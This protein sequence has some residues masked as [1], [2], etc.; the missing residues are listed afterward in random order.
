MKFWGLI[1]LVFILALAGFFLFL[2]EA[3]VIQISTQE[4]ESSTTGAVLANVPLDT[5]VTPEAAEEKPDL[6][7]AGKNSFGDLGYQTQ[8]SNPPAVIKGIYVTGWTA[9]SEKRINALV[10]LI[11]K[12]EVNAIVIDIK[13]YS[14]FISYDINDS[15]FESAGALKELRILKPNLLIKKLHDHG[16]YA[17][18]RV[19]VFQ[20]SILAKAHPEW[21][22]KNK[23]T[24]ELWRDR[25]SLAWMDP[26]SKEVWDYNVALAKDALG[27]GFDEVN[28][29]YIRF[30]SD[31]NLQEIEYPYWDGLREKH[32]AMRDFFKYL[33]ENLGEAK[34][35]ADLFGLVTVAIDDLG[36][37]QKLED[38]LLY[39]DFVAPMVYPS[40]YANG[41]FGFAS[42]ATHPYEIVHNSILGAI[43]KI[44]NFEFGIPG[45]SSSTVNNSGTLP[46]IKIREARAKLRPWLQDFDLGADYDAEKIRA[47]MRGSDEAGGSGWML[48]D[49]KNIYT[50]EALNLET[51]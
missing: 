14:G 29:D 32:L 12:T 41:V 9:G 48:W 11:D 22:L 7:P 24:G 46:A 47:Q 3:R 31:G 34:I 37:G 5:L 25:K 1:T 36:I 20:D 50:R 6:P 33:R 8:L 45:D 27:R 21:A 39:F 35:S 2:R 15:Q 30:P 49:P 42:P 23:T 17:I 28:F 26:A 16:I 18:A 10:E 43:T 44:K 13:D 19:S 38:A 51:Q 4:N 40:H